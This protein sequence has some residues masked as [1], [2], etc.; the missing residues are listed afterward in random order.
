MSS[1]KAGW[2]KI[3][4]LPRLLALCAKGDPSLN[5]IADQCVFLSRIGVVSRYPD[6]PAEPTEDDARKAVRL[7]R[8]V[9]DAMRSRLPQVPK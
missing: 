3:H 8:E 4:D 6:N 7:A 9:R 1:P 2:D 5:A